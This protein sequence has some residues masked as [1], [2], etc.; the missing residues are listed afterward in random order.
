[1]ARNTKFQMRGL[2]SRNLP[3]HSAG[4][5][6]PKM[7]GQGWFLQRPFLW[8]ANGHLLLVSSCGLPLCVSVLIFSYKD[9]RHNDFLSPQ[10]PP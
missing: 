2:I 6:K 9:I 1:V 4:G 10:L 3:A 7:C 8:L 5:Q